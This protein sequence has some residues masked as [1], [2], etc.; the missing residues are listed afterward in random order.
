MPHGTLSPCQL[1]P[2]STFPHNPS[3]MNPKSRFF[4]SAFFVFI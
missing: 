2:L 1:V 3:E 4:Y